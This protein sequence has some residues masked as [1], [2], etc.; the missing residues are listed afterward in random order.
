MEELRWLD[1]C[2]LSTGITIL[3]WNLKRKVFAIFVLVLQFFNLCSATYSE[4]IEENR[5][6]KK[7]SNLFVI[8]C[9]V[10]WIEVWTFFI[11]FFL[12]RSSMYKLLRN[13]DI[14]V[15][16]NQRQD[17]ARLSKRMMILIVSF[18][19]FLV[20]DNCRFNRDPVDWDWKLR[21]IAFG[22]FVGA[23][24]QTTSYGVMIFVTLYDWFLQLFSSTSALTLAV[25]VYFHR[26]VVNVFESHLDKLTSK[27]TVVNQEVFAVLQ[28]LQK[29]SFEFEKIFSFFPFL[30]LTSNLFLSSSF[31]LSQVIH[32][33]V[34]GMDDA[35]RTVFF[36]VAR[37]TMPTVL[38]FMVSRNNDRLFAAANNAISLMFQQQKVRSRY[39][40]L[41]LEVRRVCQW[42]ATV[43][44]MMH[45]D[46]SLIPSF[47]GALLTFSV[48]FL[49]IFNDTNKDTRIPQITHGD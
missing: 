6:S 19:L 39:I 18:N 44:S 30:T 34:F 32:P 2:L 46:R 23:D 40:C 27:G 11:V 35:I 16:R 1:N 3:P 9:Y 26:L 8:A 10:H 13:L 21:R 37:I 7:V 22:V 48:L 28:R 47:T 43:F 15:N 49:Q 5:K 38:I 41:T 42:K 14:F 29:I 45:L 36:Q 25:Y 12:K 17:L 33:E 4:F 20:L 31:I 24:S